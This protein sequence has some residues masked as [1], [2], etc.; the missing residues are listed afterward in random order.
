MA[1][2]SSRSN[3]TAPRTAA[4]GGRRPA[5]ALTLIGPPPLT[6]SAR[7]PPPIPRRLRRAHRT[8]PPLAAGL[9]SVTARCPSAPLLAP[10]PPSPQH[11]RAHRT[12]PTLNV[13]LQSVPARCWPT[14]PTRP[15]PP[16]AVYRRRRAHRTAPTP[17]VWLQSVPA[18]RQLSQPTCP[19]PASAARRPRRAHRTASTLGVWSQS[20]PAC[21]SPARPARLYQPSTTHLHRRAHRTAPTPSV[22]LQSVP[23]S[24]SL[25]LP[26]GPAPLADAV[27]PLRV[28]RPLR[29]P[30]LRR[31]PRRRPGYPRLPALAAPHR[32]SLQSFPD[33][34]APWTP[35]RLGPH[36]SNVLHNHRTGPT[37]LGRRG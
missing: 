4:L 24:R 15:S 20:V 32:L 30:A 10:P 33:W 8:A 23:A 35:C 5:R 27:Y 6:P 3:Y 37:G 14:R 26:L 19:A 31:Y 2:R 13:W 36:R 17:R 1:R 22:W 7:P 11:R 29:P 28:R 34:T 16:P 21:C 25:L 12:A 18:C 9:Q